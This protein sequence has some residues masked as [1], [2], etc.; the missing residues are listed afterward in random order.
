MFGDNNWGY[1]CTASPAPKRQRTEE[2]SPEMVQGPEKGAGDF[3]A[4]GKG[5]GKG[6]KGGCHECGGDHY[7]KDCP[8][9]KAKGGKSK[10][11][12]SSNKVPTGGTG[13]AGGKGGKKGTSKLI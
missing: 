7:V 10:G 13:G 5:K 11:K 9:R 8:V 4:K 12:G 3:A 1:I 6:P 2:Q